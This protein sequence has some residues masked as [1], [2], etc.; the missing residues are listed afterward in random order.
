MESAIGSIRAV[1]EE[2]LLRR[3]DFGMV[4]VFYGERNADWFAFTEE[5]ERWRESSINVHMT[6]S[7]PAEGTYWRG[8][9]GYVQDLMLET[10]KDLRNSVA[11]LA[12]ARGMIQDATTVLVRLGL[13]ENRILSNIYY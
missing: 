9:T 11:F 4:D 3:Q 8:Y 1:V 5:R 13:P 2:I 10:L 7:R 6:A 12:G